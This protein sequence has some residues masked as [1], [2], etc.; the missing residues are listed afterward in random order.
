MF[1]T[2]AV[3]LGLL[4]VVL[5]ASPAALSSQ[6]TS[7]GESNISNARWVNYKNEYSASHLCKASEITL[8]TCEG[9]NKTYSLCSSIDIEEKSGYIQYRVGDQKQTTFEYPTTNLHPKGIFEYATSSNGDA[10]IAFQNGDY[11]YELVDP[12]RSTS[13]IEV[14]KKPNDKKI[15]WISCGNPNQTLQLNYTIKL[16]QSAG[17]AKP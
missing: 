7:D 11:K 4:V 17:I 3:K 10:W 9:K 12:M 16:M 13:F 15:A 5:V 8:W 14:L 1:R 6:P 2:L